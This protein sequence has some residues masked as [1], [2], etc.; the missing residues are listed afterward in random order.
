VRYLKDAL[1]FSFKKISNLMSRDE[2][3]IWTTYNK[4]LSK[5]KIIVDFQ[6]SGIDF[7][8]LKLKPS[9]LIIPLS[10]FSER[11]LSILETLC[12]YI[13]ENFSLTYHN[14]SLLLERDERTIWTVIKRAEKKL[15]NA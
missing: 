4:S 10:I 6:M 14:I 7:S 13:K 2:S 9:S 3:T 12:L 11:T 8:K 15:N 5:G 1:G